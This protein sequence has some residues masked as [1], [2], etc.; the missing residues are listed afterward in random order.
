MIGDS[1]KVL[2]KSVVCVGGKPF[3]GSIVLFVEVVEV[4]RE[5]FVEFVRGGRIKIIVG[6]P[7]KEPKYSL[8]VS[9]LG[10]RS[11]GGFN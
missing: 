2:D 9:L 10:S 4:V 11:H 7:I 3:T 8:L 1:R 6:T 5:K